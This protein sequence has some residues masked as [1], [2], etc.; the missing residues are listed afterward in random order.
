MQNSQQ[1]HTSFSYRELNIVG[2]TVVSACTEV[3]WI[4]LWSWSNVFN[5][6]K[7]WPDVSYCQWKE[8]QG[9]SRRFYINLL[10]YRVHFSGTTRQNKFS[11]HV[12]RY[13]RLNQS[14][15][16]VSADTEPERDFPPS[17]ALKCQLFQHPIFKWV[18]PFDLFHPKVSCKV[19]QSAV[20]AFI[21][22]WRLEIRNRFLW[23]TE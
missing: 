2:V 21:T 23:I 9:R 12:C 4:Q 15:L 8:F 16:F 14:V 20:S 1:E 5:S 19:T 6:M 22:L 3:F 10:L 17:Y 18:I 13:P 7:L 11:V